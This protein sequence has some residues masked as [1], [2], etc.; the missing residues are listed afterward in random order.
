M[1]T[2]AS[3][4]VDSEDQVQKAIDSS[5]DQ[6]RQGKH[7]RHQ[8]KADQLKLDYDFRQAHKAI[9]ERTQA[10]GDTVTQHAG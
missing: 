1:L 9:H 6:K 5:G 7:S 2:H 4:I 3:H 8:R 10:N